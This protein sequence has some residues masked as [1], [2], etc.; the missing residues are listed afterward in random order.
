M[1][2]VTILWQCLLLGTTLYFLPEIV[3]LTTVIVRGL[4]VLTK[5]I[6]KSVVLNVVLIFVAG[7]LLIIAF[8]L[9]RVFGV[10]PPNWIKAFC[11]YLTS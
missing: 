6:V 3:Y 9:K 2:T 7:P 4:F 8:V 11:L 10:Q 1:I 5:H